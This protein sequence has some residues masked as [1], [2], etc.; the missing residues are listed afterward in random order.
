MHAWIVCIA[1]YSEYSNESVA[2]F[3][4]L[5]YSTYEYS[6]TLLDYSSGAQCAVRTL[7]RLGFV[8][9][10]YCTIHTYT[11]TVLLEYLN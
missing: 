6:R 5:D 10:K 8:L 4:V 9:Y 7:T 11:R 1:K 3:K 2:F